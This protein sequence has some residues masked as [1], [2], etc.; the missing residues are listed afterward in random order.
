MAVDD[1]PA[2]GLPVADDNREGGGLPLPAEQIGDIYA[3]S[4]EILLAKPAVV[5]AAY[6][7]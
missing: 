4:L 6:S 1:T 2:L 3:V 5:V 7:P